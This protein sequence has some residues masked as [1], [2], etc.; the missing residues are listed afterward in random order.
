MSSD[1]EG[2][3]TLDDRQWAEE[4]LRHGD[5]PGVWNEVGVGK[6]M[7]ILG[8]KEPQE[9]AQAWED[10][11][12][13]GHPP[14][15]QLWRKIKAACSERRRGKKLQDQFKSEQ[16]KS[17][18]YRSYVSLLWEHF[19]DLGYPDGPEKVLGQLEEIEIK[20]VEKIAAVIRER[21]FTERA[22]TDCVK[23]L[24][25]DIRRG[26]KAL[27]E[28]DDFKFLVKDN[29]SAHPWN[30]RENRTIAKIRELYKQCTALRDRSIA[31]HMARVFAETD[32]W[33]D[34]AQG[35]SREATYFWRLRMRF[36]KI[37]LQ[38]EQKPSSDSPPQE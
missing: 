31:T 18:F 19:D 2:N 37:D 30:A 35:K 25:E 8:I 14:R 34:T 7:R 3:R 24:S 13:F 16:D 23:V 26:L 28:K 38:S 20:T 10:W 27:R 5:P 32:F 22:V 17:E 4:Y 6:A 11:E 29:P 15:R 36:R 21:G 1:E 12:V 9:G 33:T